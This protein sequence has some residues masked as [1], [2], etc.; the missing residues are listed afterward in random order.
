MASVTM[1][2]GSL[3]RLTNVPLN[4]PIAPAARNA[5][6]T[7]IHKV[8]P[9]PM[10][11]CANNPTMIPVEPVITPAERSNSPPIINNPTATA[12]MPSG[13]ATSSHEAVLPALPNF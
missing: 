11:F 10:N 6:G 4:H 3:V 12:M 5:T 2:L 7:A 8:A 1:K 9:S 13:A